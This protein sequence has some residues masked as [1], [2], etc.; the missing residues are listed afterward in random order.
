M[1]LVVEDQKDVRESVIAMLNMEGY[2]AAGAQDGREGLDKI[3]E[4]PPSVVLLDLM[5][6][7]M[8]GLA[9]LKRLRAAEANLGSSRLP[10][11]LLTASLNSP[12][13]REAQSLSDHYLVKPADCGALCEVVNK[14]ESPAVAS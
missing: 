2:A 12:E 10:V 7:G 11:V 6:P 1:I 5:M 4:N 3:A 14:Y 13:L 9:M 8:D